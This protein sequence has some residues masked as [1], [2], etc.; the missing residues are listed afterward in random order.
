ML[1]R[2]FLAAAL[3]VTGLIA[4]PAVSSA[5]TVYD[6][7]ASPQHSNVASL[8]YEATST[9]EFGGQVQLAGTERSNPSVRVLMSSSGCQTGGGATCATTP[10]ETFPSSITLN[11]YAVNG[12]DTPGALLATKTSNFAIPFRPS[13]DPTCTTPTQWKDGTGACFNGFATPITF[14]FAGQ[15]IVLPNKVIASVAYNT[16]NH[17]YSPIGP[18]ACGAN[19][20]YDSLNVGIETLPPTTGSIPLPDDAYWATTF[21]DF[22]CDGGDGGTGTFRIDDC[23]SGPDDWSAN[24]PSFR[25][26][27]TATS[28]VV[29]NNDTTGPGPAGA[30][31]ANP[32]FSTIQGAINA[33]IPGSTILVC[34]GAYN[35]A[36][37]VDKELT[38]KGAQSGVDAT[39]RS[40]ASESV[41]NSGTSNGFTVQSFGSGSATIDGFTINHSGSSAGIGS[42]V[43]TGNLF[44]NNIISG[45]T[46]AINGPMQQATIHHNLMQDSGI[47]VEANSAPHTDGVTVVGNRFS[48][49]SNYSIHDISGGPAPHTGLLIKNNTDVGGTGNNFAV[50]DN[51]DGAQVTGNTVVNNGASAIFFGG[52]NDNTLVKGNTISGATSALSLTTLFHSEP[53]DHLTVTGN[54]L[55]AN[56]RALRATAGAITSSAEV[57]GNSI[58]GNTDTGIDNQDATHPIDAS[59]N[60]WG[61]NAG[62]VSPCNATTTGLVDSSPWLVLIASANPSTIY[63]TT[64]QSQITADL[65]HDSN[66]D[67]AAATIPD[68]IPVTFSTTG[69]IGTIAPTADTNAGRAT[70][71]LTAPAAAGTGNAVATLN[72]QAAST[73]VTVVLA[74]PG[75]PG[76]PGT[77][78]ATGDTGATGPTG[79]SGAVQGV[80]AKSC[81]KPKKLNK[82]TGKCVKKKKKK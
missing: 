4:L 10:G 31:C 18:Q 6:N 11:L 67:V 65:T 79:A 55:N 33:S 9:S 35:E 5:A 1:R 72:S 48:A 27:A 20:G 82:K 66:G 17:G 3:T 71:L 53:N 26:S 49:I 52:S 30:D 75:P 15:G 28:G 80:T 14:A 36:V 50:L 59:D 29:V 76:T 41:V 44:A 78:G 32:D 25:I 46:Y 19:C 47:G 42:F 73:P 37:S 62:P 38:I 40:A 43:G 13:A 74:P 63:A 57:H 39:T 7:I 69:S 64:G 16:T 70:A 60:W 56:A 12:D 45:E 24:Q 61:C 34:A 77:P 23:P 81:K 51:T 68:N 21:G 2:V 54:I 22:Y 8:G 58:A